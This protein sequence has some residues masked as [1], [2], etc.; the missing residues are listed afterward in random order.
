MK[1][2]NVKSCVINIPS[3]LVSHLEIPARILD[4]ESHA[5]RRPLMRLLRFIPYFR[6]T[7]T[8]KIKRVWPVQPVLTVTFHT[9][10]AVTVCVLL[11]G[12]V[13]LTGFVGSETI[14]EQSRTIA[15]PSLI[16]GLLSAHTCAMMFALRRN[17]D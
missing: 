3:F 1:N 9:A 4:R 17:A 2:P 15:N 13:V 11:I 10:A 7:K 14:L 6:R 8:I 5:E 16:A 12:A